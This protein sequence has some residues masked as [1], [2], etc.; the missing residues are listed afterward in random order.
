MLAG[1]APSAAVTSAFG[2]AAPDHAGRPA[3]SAG[4]RPGVCGRW[5]AR[6]AGYRAR[7]L[8]LTPAEQAVARLVA[9]GRPAWQT[10]AEPYASVETVGFRLGHII[11]KLG[12]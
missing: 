4:V 2:P 5:R 12:I 1:C 8:S 3:L 11:D 7:L 9:A 6:S 10:A